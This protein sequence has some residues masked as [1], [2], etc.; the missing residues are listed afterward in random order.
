VTDFLLTH[1][2]QFHPRL[3]PDKTKCSHSC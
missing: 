1:L 2:L 3:L